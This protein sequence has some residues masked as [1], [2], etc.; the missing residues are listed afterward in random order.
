M[1]IGYIKSVLSLDRYTLDYMVL[2]E[3]QRDGIRIKAGQRAMKFDEKVK[4]EERREK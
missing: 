2:E 1:K 4:K 3:T